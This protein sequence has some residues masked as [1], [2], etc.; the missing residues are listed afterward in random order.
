MQ[1][2]A[3]HLICAIDIKKA[4]SAL[5]PEYRMIVLLK[6][7]EGFTYQ[8]IA[9]ILNLPIGTVMSR[10]HRGRKVLKSILSVKKPQKIKKNILE[11]RK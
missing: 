11:L 3:D 2:Q 7:L 8:E 9:G 1:V 4:F 5:A 6:D 10:L